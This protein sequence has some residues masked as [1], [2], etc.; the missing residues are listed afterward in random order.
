MALELTSEQR[1]AV[2]RRSGSL[3]LHAGAGSGKTRVL[4]ERFVRAVLDDEVAVERILAITFTEKAAAE[5]KGRLRARFLELGER[6]HAR[7]A[8]AAWVSTIHGFCSRVLRTGAL[9][10]GIDPEYRVLD[11][12]DAARLSIDAFD[13]A[14]EEF[15][16]RA[17]SDGGE[18]LDLVASYTP[19][20]LQRMVTTVY[21]RLRSR[22][23]RAPK[24]EPIEPP[25]VGDERAALER[26]L[27]AASGRLGSLD[28]PN[29]TVLAALNQLEGCSKLL[30]A[31]PAGALGDAAEFEGTRVKRGNA[32]ALRDPVFDSLDEALSAWAAVCG[33]RK[34]YADYVLMAKLLDLYGRRYAGLKDEQSALDFDDLELRAR[35]LLREETALREAV[36]GRFE[37]VMVDEYQDTNPLQNELLELVSRDNLFTVGDERQS[38]Y[39]FRNA[40]VGVFRERRDRALAAGHEARLAVNFRSRPE[41]IDGLNG[42]FGEVFGHEF[43]PSSVPDGSDASGGEPL[44]ELLV[45]NNKR[46]CWEPLGEHPFGD[47][48]KG[49]PVWRAAEA[50]LLALRVDEL[51][52]AGECSVGEVAVLLRAASDMGVYE[53]A[54][55]ERGIPTYATGSGGY[56]GQQQVADLRSYL[57]ALANPR[58]DLSLYNVLASPLCGA[59]LDALPLVRGRARAV[60]RDLWWALEEAFAPD[61]DGS[62]GLALALPSGDRDRVGDFVRRF[63]VE[64]RA[65]PRMSL[66]SLIDRAVTESGYDSVVLALPGGGRRMANVRKL[67]RLAREY[68]AEAGRDLRGFIDFVDERELLAAREGEAPLEGEGIDAVRLMTVHAAKGLEFPVVCVADLGRTGRGDD[69]ALQVS[70]DGRVGLEVASLGGGSHSAMSMKEI[71]TEQEALAEEE[72]RRIFYVAMTRAQRRLIVSGATDT[73]DWPGAKPLGAPLDWV[74]PAL[75]PGAKLLFEDAAEG[76]VERD[77]VAVRCVLLTPES[78]D[79]VLPVGD[80]TPATPPAAPS[81]PATPPAAPSPP[82]FPPLVEGAPL[83]V[84][85]LSYSALES[86]KRCGYRFY[87]ERVVKMPRLAASLTT[88]PGAPDAGRDGDDDQQLSLAPAPVAPE[89]LSPLVRGTIV[90]ELLER[91]DFRRPRAPGRADIERQGELNRVALTEGDVRDISTLL[92]RFLES[93]VCARIRQARRVRQ[94]LPFAYALDR[95]LINGVVDVHAEEAERL[96]VVDYKTDALD[97]RDPEAVCDEKYSG[98][99][100]VYALAGLRTNAEEVEVAY[101]FLERPDLVVARRFTQ[102]H[103]DALEAEL[104]DLAGGVIAGHFEPTGEPHRELC[105]FCPGQ[106]AL[107]KWTSDRTLAERPEGETFAAPEPERQLS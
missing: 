75:A 80:R 71:K 16:L 9:L 91:I 2:D 82:A 81:P 101:C 59:S 89:A 64:R 35:D 44:I 62:E 21:S 107:C 88:P 90:H 100:L 93:D 77:G 69:G 43:V 5:L 15:V 17:S 49:V 54:L 76:V 60:G 104:L 94:E 57:A 11:E 24:L 45:V 13:R 97:G 1:A 8:E 63:A 10:A 19:D 74:W 39:G 25:V 87:L 78:A 51:V 3:F 42:A 30:G 105:Q 22:G 86:Y 26:A 73:A 70:A 23:Q 103:R 65:A 67:M 41:L 58:D 12:A 66:E 37:H 47:F 83:P 18:R 28:S 72:E 52:R 99:R 85:R 53:R 32:T 84:A 79:T 50:R 48:G 14:L 33:G 98:Q 40:D 95:V 7:E 96:L 31:L 46:R 92:D 56:W 61:G 4:V 55:N 34:A 106:P 102:A 38:I 6:E 68:E 36:C 29:K 20:K 27:A